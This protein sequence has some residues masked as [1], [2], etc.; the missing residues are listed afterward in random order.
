M[1]LYTCAGMYRVRGCVGDGLT[2]VNMYVKDGGKLHDN[3]MRYVDRCERCV[4]VV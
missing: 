1:R 3:K 4:E 2:S